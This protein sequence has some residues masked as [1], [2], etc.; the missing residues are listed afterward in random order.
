[1]LADPG[2]PTNRA[3]DFGK[4]LFDIRTTDYRIDTSRSG[5]VWNNSIAS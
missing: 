4:R 3:Y 1:M 5:S 2:E